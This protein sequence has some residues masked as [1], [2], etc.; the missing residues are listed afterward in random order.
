MKKHE[1]CEIKLVFMNIF[2]VLFKFTV[3]WYQDGF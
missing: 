2:E 1:F 3:N